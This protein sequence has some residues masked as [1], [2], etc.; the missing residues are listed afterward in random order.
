M[1]TIRGLFTLALFIAFIGLVIWLF[2][3]RSRHDFD[4]AARIPFEQDDHGEND[5]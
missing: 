4:D 3:F 1:G 2:V 5:E